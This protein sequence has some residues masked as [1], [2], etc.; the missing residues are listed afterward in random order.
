MKNNTTKHNSFVHERLVRTVYDQTYMLDIRHSHEI[1]YL[2]IMFEYA[3]LTAYA[4]TFSMWNKNSFTNKDPY[5]CNKENS[6]LYSMT[7][8]S[9]NIPLYLSNYPTVSYIIVC[10]RFILMCG[11]SEVYSMFDILLRYAF[12]TSKFISFVV[13]S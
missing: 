2:P 5:W 8:I 11:F 4:Y 7:H 6:R 9:N 13:L 10:R 1:G 12:T 3:G